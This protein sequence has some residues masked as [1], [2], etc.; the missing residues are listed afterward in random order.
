MLVTLDDVRALVKAAA[1]LSDG[2]LTAVIERIESEITAMIGPPQDDTGLVTH[3]V[4]L[5][6]EGSLLFMPSEIGSITSVVEDTVT[7]AADEY[8]MWKAEIERLPVGGTWGGRCVVTYCPA[9]DR[10]K[11]KQVIIDLCRIDIERTAQFQES[12]GGEYSYTAPSNWE[13]ERS[14]VLRRMRMGVV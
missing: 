14:R 3:T 2:Q 13:R 12:V 10:L 5:P 11:R 4:T 9:D 8:R 6:G 7:L 1:I